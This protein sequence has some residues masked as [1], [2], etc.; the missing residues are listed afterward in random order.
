MKFHQWE[1]GVRRESGPQM[2]R[3]RASGLNL[4]LVPPS[5][6]LEAR[7]VQTT[8][9]QNQ[10]WILFIPEQLLH[11]LLASFPLTGEFFLFPLLFRAIISILYYTFPLSHGA[12]GP[13]H[14]SAY[15]V[16]LTLLI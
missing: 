11:S 15:V 1:I 12:R 10:D 14:P 9:Y 4:F 5:L 7:L 13:K 3:M 2:L 6:T 8:M 16:S